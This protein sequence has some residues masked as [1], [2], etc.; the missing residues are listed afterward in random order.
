MIEKLPKLHHL[1]LYI[2]EFCS[3]GEIG[4]QTIING[5]ENVLPN[6]KILKFYFLEFNDC[7]DAS[8]KSF[9]ELMEQ[10][11]HL[12]EID[13]KFCDNYGTFIGY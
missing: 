12:E 1:E 2:G 7:G 4:F 13:L 10:M 5:I 9:S 11:H 8:A 3:V 6:L